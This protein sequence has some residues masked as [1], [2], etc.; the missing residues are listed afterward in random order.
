MPAW[1]D[2]RRLSAG[3]CALTGV[4]QAFCIE[5]TAWGFS[6]SWNRSGGD[7]RTW[8]VCG[9]RRN[10][11]RRK[12]KFSYARD[13]HGDKQTKSPHPPTIRREDKEA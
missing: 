3:Q 6:T 8:V 4:G 7:C 5:G 2:G 10:V 9:K 1:S 13:L 12:R 11:K